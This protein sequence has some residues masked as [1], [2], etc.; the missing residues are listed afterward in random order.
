MQPVFRTIMHVGPHKTGTSYLQTCFS[1]HSDALRALG[2]VLPRAWEEGPGNF[3]HTGLLK[4][5][6]QE[7]LAAAS[8]VLA[9]CF[10]HGG[11]TLLISAEGLS[12]VGLESLRRLKTL[13]GSGPVTIVYYV[14]R[15]SDHFPSGWQELVKNGAVITLP[16]QFANHIRNPSQS[17]IFN[18]DV[19]LA[20]FRDVFGPDNIRIVC[21]SEIRDR[22]MNLF[23]HFMAEILGVPDA[24]P[25]A[26]VG[27]LNISRGPAYI[28][29]LRCLNVL[30]YAQT[31]VR[32]VGLR[33]KLQA[34]ESRIDTCHL[35]TAMAKHER[36]LTFN[37]ACDA[38]RDV[39][40]HLF[41]RY[42]DAIVPPSRQDRFFRPARRAIPYISA[43]YLMEPGLIDI[44]RAIYQQIIG[45]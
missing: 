1:R 18:P 10:E 32:P 20:P 7:N 25:P 12:T 34:I 31:G 16:E 44:I 15:W 23:T 14:R 30:E 2:V 22:G 45:V 21:Y 39:H 38:L 11:T 41:E 33:A 8:D 43:D 35:F 29:L 27:D 36:V 37:D 4:A 19:R 40:K 3:S 17:T 26:G 28:E 24:M 6:N 13:L 42:K 9:R 5:L